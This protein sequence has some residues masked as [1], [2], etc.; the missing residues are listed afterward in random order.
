MLLVDDNKGNDKGVVW[1]E[2]VDEGVDE[3]SLKD[4]VNLTSGGSASTSH[5]IATCSP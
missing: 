3:V 2:D 1:D 5:V 4:Q